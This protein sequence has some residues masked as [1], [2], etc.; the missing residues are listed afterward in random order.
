[1]SAPSRRRWLHTVLATSGLVLLRQVL[2]QTGPAPRIITMSARR[3]AYEPREIPL[4][5]G[6]R[7]VIEI[8]SID[9]VHGMNIP[10]LKLRLD[11]V[12]GQVTRFELAPDKA[13]TIEFLCDN[14]CGDGHEQM[15]GRFVV[16][17]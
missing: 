13:G 3:F 11:L 6:E 4:K 15:Q 1:M 17:A 12:P 5:R 9:F 2:A 8:R 10:D 14:F 7:V 16:S